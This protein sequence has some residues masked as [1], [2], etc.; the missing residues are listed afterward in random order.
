MIRR[1][2]VLGA[3]ASLPIVASMPSL[4]QPTKVLRFVPNADLAVLDPI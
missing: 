3:I 4:A 2:T 1:C